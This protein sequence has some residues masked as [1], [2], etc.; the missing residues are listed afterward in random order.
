MF[1]FIHSVLDGVWLLL[2]LGF[3]VSI[4]AVVV[5]KLKFGVDE[6]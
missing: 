5:D 3:G 4:V 6:V 2:C 1:L